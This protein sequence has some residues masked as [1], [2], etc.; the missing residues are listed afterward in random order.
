MFHPSSMVW[1]LAAF[2]ASFVSAGD[3]VVCIITNNVPPVKE[4]S[5]KTITEDKFRATM[6]AGALLG[7][8]SDYLGELC[9]DGDFC[10]L[11]YYIETATCRALPREV[12]DHCPKTSLRSPHQSM[13]SA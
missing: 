1:M 2:A 8:C 11:D 9:D 10:T 6:V 4:F 7:S 3:V 5:T 12:V 13:A